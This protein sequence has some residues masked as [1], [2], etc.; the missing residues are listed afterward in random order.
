MKKLLRLLHL[1][2]YYLYIFI[3]LRDYY[4][5]LLN[6]TIFILWLVLDANLIFREDSY[7]SKQT[8][9]FK[10]SI[11]MLIWFFSSSFMILGYNTKKS[12][13]TKIFFYRIMLAQAFLQ[14]AA[15][16][17]RRLYWH[18]VR[19][20]GNWSRRK[21][22]TDTTLAMIRQKPSISESDSFIAQF[23]FLYR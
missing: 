8:E 3:K 16:I 19:L 20:R 2:Y 10:T 12:N 22:V 14:S 11:Y 5:W 18:L 6:T 21:P 17:T 13:L 15:Q 9:H 1:S 4:L 23:F 7:V